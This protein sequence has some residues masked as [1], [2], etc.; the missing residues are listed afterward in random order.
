MSVVEIRDLSRNAG[1]GNY[2]FSAVGTAE[3]DRDAI[4]NNLQPSL[5]DLIMSHDYPGLASWA[6]FSPSLRD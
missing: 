4:L 5:R 1:S 6:K 3:I 2:T